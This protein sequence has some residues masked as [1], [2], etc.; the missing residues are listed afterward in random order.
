M[1]TPSP[2]THFIQALRTTI[3]TFPD[4]RKGK[5]KPYALVEAAL[6][7]LAVVFTPSP[8][9]LAYQRDRAARKGQRNAPPLFGLHDM[10]SD[11]QS[12]ILL[13]PVSPELRGPLFQHG[14]VTLAQTP[15]LAGLRSWQ[16]RRLGVWDGTQYFA[17]QK[18][19]CPQGSTRTPATGPTTSSPRRLTPGSAAPGQDKVIP[20]PPE[21]IV[22][23]EGH[24]KQGC[25]T[26]AAQ[27]GLRQYARY[28]RAYGIPILGDELYSNHPRGEVL[29]EE[30]V[31]FILACRPDSPPTRYAQLADRELGQDLHP[32][33]HRP[34]TAQ[35]LALDR[36]RYASPRPLRAPDAARAVQWGELGGTTEQGTRL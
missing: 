6:G 13:D 7:A 25:E 26:A 29:V 17:S 12:R 33:T 4:Q 21:F 35:G 20:L 14:L 23:Q 2:A 28:S 31:P 11:K 30:Q 3:A 19:S 18:I 16:P 32:V 24:D 5:K 27:R 9:F 8:A 15:P 10:P 34:H 1:S 22:P 36:Y